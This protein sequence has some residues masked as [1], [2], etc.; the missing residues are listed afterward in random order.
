MQYK[1]LSQV[2]GGTITP[3]AL[4]CVWMDLES[5]TSSVREEFWQYMF[6]MGKAFGDIQSFIIQDGKITERI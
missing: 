2:C 6:E 1:N 3:L 4:K 5:Q